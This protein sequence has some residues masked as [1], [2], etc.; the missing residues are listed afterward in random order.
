MDYYEILGVTRNATQVEIRNAYRR[1]AKQYH[2]DRNPSEEAK[3]LIQL[4]NQAYDVLSDPAKKMAYDQPVFTFEIPVTKEDPKAAYRREFLRKKRQE[5]REAREALIQFKRKIGNFIAKVN[6]VIAFLGAL[7]T[8][9]NYLP[10]VTYTEEFIEGK[11][12][13]SSI[14]NRYQFTSTDSLPNNY[15]TYI[16][17]TTTFIVAVPNIVYLF[18]RGPTADKTLQIEVS[19]LLRVPKYVSMGAEQGIFRPFVIERTIYSIGA[20]FPLFI[21]IP[22][23]LIIL[24]RYK[25]CLVGIFITVEFFSLVIL[26]AS[27]G[28][29]MSDKAMF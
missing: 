25:G 15:G 1:L 14:D 22:A 20:N 4:I 9:D 8:I 16:I 26:F 11:G 29:R 3:Q 13:K 28:E 23:L 18:K 7:L 12:L 27:I 10:T 19:P 17:K 2:P 21:L 6:Y 24:F 5:E